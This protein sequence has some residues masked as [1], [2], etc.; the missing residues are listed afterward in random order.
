M[1]QQVETSQ[2]VAPTGALK[3][4]PKRD[5]PISV[6]IITQNEE[7]SLPDCMGSLER[8]CEVY[9][10]DSASTDRTLEIAAQGG[11]TPV[12]FTWNGQYPKKKQWA[13]D[14]LPL[15][16]DWVLFMDADERVSPALAQEMAD[17][18]A[19]G[20][21]VAMDVRLHYMFLGRELK[22]GHQ[23]MKRILMNRTKCFFPPVDDL[24]VNNMWEVEGHYQPVCKGAV[25]LSEAQLDHVDED[26][27]YGYFSRHNRYSD[28]EAYLRVHPS[29]REGVASARSRQGKLFDRIPGKPFVFFVYAYL[30]RQ[31]FRD[32]RAG[33]HYA[34]A[35]S[36]YYWQIYVKTLE[37]NGARNGHA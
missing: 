29:V 18:V 1:T 35:L 30:I 12:S 9:V 16:S 11:A 14:T 20:R 28:W 31:G 22:H 7:L 17:F 8:F 25:V 33:L 3:P 2:Q 19:E 37:L 5:I 6:I 13:L 15:L 21:G 24:A 23:V 34:L 32:G 4:A 26:P 10:V 36:F 27:L